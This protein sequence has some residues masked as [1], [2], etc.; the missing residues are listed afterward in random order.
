[1]NSTGKTLSF[2]QTYWL[3][4][5]GKYIDSYFHVLRIESNGNISGNQYMRHKESGKITYVH[6]NED[7]HTEID[8][9]NLS[10]WKRVKKPS[11]YPRSL[12]N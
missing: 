4:Y 9:S 7:R 11:W 8:S 12:S 5:R 1:M 6:N 3:I 2:N 10:L